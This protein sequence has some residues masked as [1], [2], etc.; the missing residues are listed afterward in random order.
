VGMAE[1]WGASNNFWL[2]RRIIVGFELMRRTA[3]ES[4][5]LKWTTGAEV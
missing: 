5:M 4:R 1:S 3:A 2:R